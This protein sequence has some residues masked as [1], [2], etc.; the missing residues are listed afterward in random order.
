MAEI[1]AFEFEVQVIQD[2][3]LGLT[4]VTREHRAQRLM[5]RNDQIECSVQ[6]TDIQLATDGHRSRNV[7]AGAVGLELADEP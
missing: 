6:L 1:D 2:L 5:P 3:L 7:V 4:L